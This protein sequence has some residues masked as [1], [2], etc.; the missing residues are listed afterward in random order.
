MN[1]KWKMEKGKLKQGLGLLILGI[2]FLNA[3]NL[4]DLFEAVKQMPDTK[5]DNVAVQEMQVNKKNIVAK[6]YPKVGVFSSYEHFSSPA[7]VKPMPPTVSGEITKSKGGYWFSQ[8]I[9]KVGFDISMPLFVKSIYD[10]KKKIEFLINSK[11]YQAKL[12]LLKREALLVGLVS[13]FDYLLQLQKALLQKEA[14]IETT[15]NA[16]KVG[17][18]VGRFPKFKEL[19][20][21]DALNQVQIKITEINSKIDGVKADIYKLT[22]K[23]VTGY[24]RV[25]GA[26]VKEQEFLALKS[27]KEG[28]KAMK[29][30]VDVQKDDYLPQIFLKAQGYRAFAKA[31]NND[32]NLALNFANIGLYLKWNLFD[33][34]R[35]A[36]IQ[37]SK[38]NLLKT[39]L[40]L[41]KTVKDLTAEVKKI[42]CSIKDINRALNLQQNSIAL[43]EELLKS[44]KVAFKIN[45]MSVDDYLNYETDL[46]NAKANLANL[47]ATKN[48]LLANLAFIYGNNLERVFK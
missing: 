1:R 27:L 36:A 43:K 4:D 42:K 5:I 14:S 20:L 10:N 26:D 19:K 23:D 44:A 33:K 47:K 24:I 38:I 34:S 32:D 6:L 7:N 17:V 15:L 8:N 9:L 46:A 11:K 21:Q 37:K 48:G 45:S 18:E 3:T 16:I 2:S 40:L 41:Q 25:S 28:L 31:Y 22:K 35:S 29:V 12:S 13:K 39:N 30:D